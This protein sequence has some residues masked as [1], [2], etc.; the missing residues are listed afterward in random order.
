MISD[1]FDSSL[2]TF[3]SHQQKDEFLQMMRVTGI[4]FH[5]FGN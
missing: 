3:H 5:R 1:K 2:A 4:V